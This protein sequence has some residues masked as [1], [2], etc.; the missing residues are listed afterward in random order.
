MKTTTI[1]LTNLSS[2]INNSNNS[3]DGWKLS[4]LTP[5]LQLGVKHIVYIKLLQLGPKEWIQKLLNVIF[6]DQGQYWI[7]SPDPP[8]QNRLGKQDE[9]KSFRHWGSDKLMANYARFFNHRI[10]HF[11]DTFFFPSRLWRFESTLVSRSHETLAWRQLCSFARR[12]WHARN[13]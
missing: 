9:S 7:G 6:E 3:K 11:V 4:F 13:P 2:M 5:F 10:P 12:F 8:N 1:T